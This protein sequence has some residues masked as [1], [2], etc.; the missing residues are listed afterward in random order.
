MKMLALVQ[1][2]S[3]KLV[4][5]GGGIGGKYSHILLF[6]K[7]MFLKGV[8]SSTVLTVELM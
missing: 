4:E 3:H 2:V 6:T 5:A 7:Y 8:N 1:T